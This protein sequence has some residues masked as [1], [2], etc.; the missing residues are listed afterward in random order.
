[1]IDGGGGWVGWRG[2]CGSLSMDAV[3]CVIEAHSLSLSQPVSI[4]CD[5][6]SSVF[7]G[8][9]WHNLYLLMIRGA[10]QSGWHCY[11]HNL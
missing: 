4:V 2:V 5:L 9:I 8:I 10:H 3:H 7:G 1:L 6:C 11:F